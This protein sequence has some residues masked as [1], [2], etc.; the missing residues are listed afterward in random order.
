MAGTDPGVFDATGYRQRVLSKLRT[1]VPLDIADPFFVVDL[2]VDV[3]DTDLIRA[4]IS[5][6]VAFW[7]KE[8]SPNYKS[9]AADL[10]RR[11]SEL[12]AV[13]LDPTAR[14]AAADRVRAVRAAA[15]A[16]G[17]ADLNEL[18]G[19]LVARFQGVPRSRVSHLAALARSKGLDD[20]AFAAWV[21]GH[22]II[23]DS[24][25]SAEPLT[26]A[27]RRKIRGD[28]DELGRLT[29]DAARSAT[30]WTIL[31]LA[32]T[33]TT[34]EIAAKHA[35][36]HADNQRRPHDRLQTV[37]SN[38]L[39]YV[40]Q[41][42]IIGE[43]TRYAAS[44]VEDAKDRLG[45]TVAE[46]VIVDGSL[47]A[48]DFEASVQ[49]A[50][51]FGFGLSTEQA[52]TA[53]R[54]VATGLGASVETGKQVDYVVCAH[55]RE[56]QPA[57]GNSGCRYCGDDLY[58]SCPACGQRVEASAPACPHCGA[59][60][61]AIR[62]AEEQLAAARAALGEGRPAAAKTLLV[63]VRRAAAA[64]PQLAR[65]VDSVTNEV[66]RVLA[67]A[68]AAWSTV[69]RDIAER[70][71]YAAV[72]RLARIAPVASDVPGPKNA[73]ATER[74]ADLAGRKAE[75][76]A[77]VAAARTLPSAEKEA[78]LA[79]VLAV[80][81][82]CAE[83]LDLLAALPLAAPGTPTAVATDHAVELRWDPS[84]APSDVTYK[85]TRVVTR[86]DGGLTD[87]RA[88]GTTGAC[89]F[90]DAGVAGGCLV[91]HEVVAI[92]GR[93][94][95]PAVSTKSILIVRDIAHLAARI[96]PDGVTLSWS[97]VAIAGTVVIE[98]TVENPGGLSLPLRRA[99][100]DGQSWTDPDVP[101][102]VTFAYRVYVE[103][104][105]GTGALVRTPG[106]RVSVRVVPRPQPVT[107]LW[108]T[109]ATDGTTTVTWTMPPT[110][111]VRIYA[112]TAP[113]AA[114]DSDVDLRALARA[115]R[116]VGS[117]RRRVVD[118][119]AR[120]VVSYTA[121]TIDE[122][123]AVA[124]PS[125]THLAVRFA[126]D[127]A[128]HDTG[129][130]LV[131]T[132]TLPP[133]V[134]EAVVAA[135]RDTYPASPDDPA[136]Q[137]WKVTNT[138]LELSGGLHIAAPPDGAAWYLS[139]H[140]ALRD[141]KQVLVAPTG[142]QLQARAAKP[143]IATYTVRR[144]GLRRRTLV[145]EVTADGPLPSLVVRVKP[146]G[147][148]ASARDGTELGRL[149]GGAPTARLEVQVGA[150][151]LPAGVRVFAT[152]TVTGRPLTLTDPPDRALLVST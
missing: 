37:T 21:G 101:F 89:E 44:L 10:A 1:A 98:R 67:A 135:R 85:V 124:G 17:Y 150:L 139:V 11:R 5:A 149:D 23:Q 147:V 36:L 148:P 146:N 99:R 103:Y 126:A 2:P 15:D 133:G 92:S 13:L 113:L 4:R 72:D 45:A 33:A 50:M 32:P 142:V 42:L 41:W 116:F 43:R 111:E 64:V 73:S 137:T 76:Q 97:L 34:E 102:G 31:D 130:E 60:F 87:T 143:I 109:T 95:S 110:G 54:Q 129:D 61:R 26:E 70:R 117:G 75:V 40:K 65:D 120:G 62:A 84:N 71:L 57:N 51:G 144:N 52:R 131:V 46:K 138:K 105:D 20:A 104:R 93:R 68:A 77:E 152:G 151:T 132:F 48:G 58:V 141:G 16:D 80:A 94:T 118:A 30:L 140:T 3:D 39:T 18:A 14:A 6:L 66:E 55:C 88:V 74:L 56:P 128:V 108:A 29:G 19:K 35:E 24:N 59:S 121:V 127:A 47:S 106:G 25:A 22:R 96:G 115:G 78:A 8:R 136:A 12:E 69:G 81:S 7:N 38:T 9:I 86:P 83:A 119:H 91:H 82:D 114:A 79:R 122:D 125:I 145:V 53:V 123:R 63:G 28:L 49:K 100:A 90:E 27:V 112:A 134:T 107:E